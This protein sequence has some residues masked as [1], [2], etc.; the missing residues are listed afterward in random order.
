[1]SSGV[2]GEYCLLE[3]VLLLLAC[4]MLGSDIIR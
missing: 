2:G 4:R 1:M 3:S